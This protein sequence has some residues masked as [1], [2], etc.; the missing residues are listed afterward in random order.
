MRRNSIL[1][2]ITAIAAAGLGTWLMFDAEPGIGWAIWTT[3]AA[4]ALLIFAQSRIALIASIAAIATI[5]AWGAAI[6]AD[7]VVQALICFSVIL[8]LALEMLLSGDPRIDRITP[9]FVATAPVVAFVSAIL[10][11]LGRATQALHVIRS[12]RAR[13][14]VRGIAITLPV[15]IVFGLLLSSA[16]PIFAT[17]RENLERIFETWDFLPR[18]IFFFGLLAITLGAYG[19]AAN[20]A[21]HPHQPPVITRRQ[22]LGDTERMILIGSVAALLWG[23]LAIQLS[24]LFGNV[25]QTAGSGMSFSEYA[26]R[27]FAELTVVASATVFLI[28]FCERFG[29]PT[30]RKTLLHTLT[31]VLIVAVLFLLGSAFRRVILYEDAYGFT[32]SRL[33]AQTYMLVVAVVLIALILELRTQL[34]A[35]RL[36]RVAA[37]TATT[38]AIVLIYWNHEAWIAGQNLDRV[39]ATGK[40]DVDYLA[41][42][43]SPNAVPVIVDRLPAIPEPFRTELQNRLYKRYASSRQLAE[44][45]WYEYSAR[46]HEARSALMKLGIPASSPA[47]KP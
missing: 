1:L 32:T 47:T 46:R 7:P 26:R 38:A 11:S 40:L 43:L 17:W 16:D 29:E 37:F 22:W 12:N 18:T 27:G 2:W 42:D 45:N 31:I 13:S 23:F 20:G 30:R 35:S 33:Y 24:Y 4:A 6:T 21:A 5:I 10:E 44:E 19:F 9:L 15:I 25:A 28:L 8:F 39:A 41:R 14:V 36:F 3:I 34:N